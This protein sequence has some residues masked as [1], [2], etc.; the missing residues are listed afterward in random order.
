MEKL[1]LGLD[2]L[3]QQQGQEGEKERPQLSAQE[4]RRLK[5]QRCI[6]SL[7]HATHCREI[8]CQHLSCAKMKRVVEHTKTCKRK[9][10]GGCRICQELIHLCCYHA[11]HCLERECV[12]PFCR[13]IK[14]KLRQQQTQQRFAQSQT[15]RRRMAT[16]QRQ[17]MQAPPQ[18]PNQAMQPSMGGPGAIG[19]A[20]PA[21]Q[22]PQQQ[23]PPY[24]PPVMPQKPVIS[25]P[26]PRAVEAA[27][28]IAQAATM[29]A[30]GGGV[31][32]GLPARNMPHPQQVFQPQ[33]PPNMTAPPGSMAP[34]GMMRHQNPALL[35]QSM[36]QNMPQGM[37]PQS[38]PQPMQQPMQQTMPQQMQP[39]SGAPVQPNNPAALEWYSKQQQQQQMNHP[40]A[41]MNAGQQQFPQ[42]PG[43]QQQGLTVGPQQNRPNMAVPALQQLLYTLKA[44]ST[45]QQQAK[46]LSILKQHPQLLASFIKHRKQRQEAQQQQQQQH[47]HHEKQQNIFQQLPPVSQM[48]AMSLEEKPSSES[49]DHFTSGNDAST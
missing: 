16:M 5:I 41:M 25:G 34:S 33:Q 13:H 17:G 27:Q 15:L 48:N 7:V 40:N 23:P 19:Q 37:P 20:H 2:D 22:P 39:S 36:G 38:I 49:N 6:Q 47:Q 28:K 44:P 18:M 30:V 8:N 1:G 11:K 12:V 14:L 3:D 45:P 26:P 21:L 32:M 24:Q 4:E 9:T 31:P 46:V 42:L 10:G 29:Q 35:Q 43:G